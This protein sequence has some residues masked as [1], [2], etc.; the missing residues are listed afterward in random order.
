MD[1]YGRSQHIDSL[2]STIAYSI[3]HIS[4]LANKHIEFEKIHAKIVLPAVL[5]ELERIN[6]GFVPVSLIIHRGVIESLDFAGLLDCKRN[7]DKY[8]SEVV[9]FKTSKLFEKYITFEF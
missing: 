4:R 2:Q 9:A 3:Y 7:S 6:Q 8:Y 1:C 5:Q